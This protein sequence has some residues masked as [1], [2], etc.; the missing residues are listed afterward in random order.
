[1]SKPGSMNRRTAL[2]ALSQATAWPLAAYAALRT[3]SSYTDQRK[4]LPVFRTA[5]LQIAPTNDWPM[6]VSDGQL[7][8]A[9]TKLRLQRTE[10][11]AKINHV[12]HAL[13]MW[14][15]EVSFSDASVMG[16]PE[17]LSLLID[18]ATLRDRW[19][20]DV[21]PLLID[22]PQGVRVRTQEGSATSSHIDHTLATLAE[23]GLPSD[24]KLR[25]RN[26]YYLI[27]DMLEQA[28]RSFS[29]NQQEYEWTALILGL[30][31]QDAK[32][33]YTRDGQLVDFDMIAMR[34]MRESL[35]LG[36]CHGGH[37]LFTLAMLKRIDQQERELFSADTRHRIEEHLRDATVRLHRTQHADGYWDAAWPGY[38]PPSSKELWEQGMRLVATGH[39]LE[40]WAMVNDPDLLPPRETIV[41]GGQWLSQQV[42]AMQT[43]TV[44]KNFTFLTHVGRALSMWRSELP[45]ESWIRLSG[46]KQSTDVETEAREAK[47]ATNRRAQSRSRRGF[48][49]STEFILMVTVTLVGMLVGFVAY[50]DSIV[51]ELGDTAA[52]VASLNQSFSYEGE[53]QTGTFGT[54]I[55]A[56]DYNATVAGS[57]YEDN[58]DFCETVLDTAG[59]APVCIQIDAT[60][61]ADEG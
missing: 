52:S 59:A 6:V 34:L 33:F 5:P 53:T 25:T 60:S 23:I 12:D 41:R 15:H 56:I 11:R 55:S 3:R 19:G 8:R 1:M 17:M 30:Y 9:L 47:T 61:I 21:R 27:K 43:A 2:F 35:G 36:V 26:G 18:D 54:G 57:D 32:S 28:T 46:D 45:A 39:A 38:K 10:T 50:R 7:L 44:Q 51:Q 42:D 49:L 48:I 37:R 58:S 14:G 4:R 20:K 40:W 31:L 16:G 29:L 13:R 24:T 22:G